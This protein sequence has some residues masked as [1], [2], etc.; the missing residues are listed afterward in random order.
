MYCSSVAAIGFLC[1]LCFQ[2]LMTVLI[3]L[4]LNMC[5]EVILN[6]LQER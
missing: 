5:P 4:C 1:V 2:M 3:L 6:M